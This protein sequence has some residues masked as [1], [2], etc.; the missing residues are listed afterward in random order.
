MQSEYLTSSYTGM[1]G[2]INYLNNF[3]VNNYNLNPD[4]SFHRHPSPTWNAVHSPIPAPMA[5]V[6][7]PPMQITPCSSPPLYSYNC[8]LF[9]IY[10]NGMVPMIPVMSP[11]PAH[12]RYTS[13][14]PAPTNIAYVAGSPAPMMPAQSV[15]PQPVMF[16]LPSKLSSTIPMAPMFYA[17]PSPDVCSDRGYSRE[18]SP[19]SG[20]TYESVSSTESS[21]FSCSLPPVALPNHTA[22][23]Q[24]PPAAVKSKKEVVELALS[25]VGQIFGKRMQIAGLRGEAV[26][27]IKVKT[28]PSLELIVDLLEFLD[29]N[30][31]IAAINC[32]KSTKK[33]KQHIRGFLVY[34]QMNSVQDVQQLKMLFDR[35]NSMHVNGDSLPFKQVEINPQSKAKNAQRAA[36]FTKKAA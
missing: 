28:R 6:Q 31:S 13:P 11:G 21:L 10:T 17:T 3:N 23:T 36:K 29:A 4:A 9:P 19:D 2:D 34:L 35:F 1:N 27:R 22:T 20:C 24:P 33:G 30:T 32:P 7:S 25:Q 14:S 15:N 12:L 26:A 18:S 8:P 16:G 5:R